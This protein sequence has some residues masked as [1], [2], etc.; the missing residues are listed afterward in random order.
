MNHTHAR[1]C[2][3]F[4]AAAVLLVTF[5]QATATPGLSTSSQS[6]EDRAH[7]QAIKRAANGAMLRRQR[8]QHR[9]EA[10]QEMLSLAR[11]SGLG[12][13]DIESAL[14]HAYRVERFDDRRTAWMAVVRARM[15]AFSTCQRTMLDR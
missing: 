6:A 5:G 3:S 10:L 1:P 7:C 2:R 12:Q 13:R 8:G 4:I 11:G 9:D 15:Q 14:D